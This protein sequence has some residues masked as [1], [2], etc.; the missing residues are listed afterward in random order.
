[1]RKT[2]LR[3]A[4]AAPLAL[5]LA[6]CQKEVLQVQNYNAPDV[7]RVYATPA[8]IEG[9]L[10]GGYQTV[11]SS[12]RGSSEGLGTQSHNM[13]LE[14]Y[15]SVANFGG[16]TRAAIPRIAIFNDR[17]NSVQTGN[18]RDFQ[19]LSK[20]AR[21]AATGVQAL[22][23]LVTGGGTLGSPAQNTRARAFGF[24]VNGVALGYLSFGYD[25]SAIVTVMTPSDEVPPLASY[26]DVNKAA[27]QMLDSALAVAQSAD[28]TSGINGFPLPSTW[29]TYAV[30]Q[31]AFVRLV[32]SERARIRAGVARTPA[33]RAAVDWNAVI[34]DATAGISA[35]FKLAINPTTG[36]SC[37]FDCSQMEVS[38][39]WGQ[40]SPMYYGMTDTSGFYARWIATPIGQRDGAGMFIT[41]D[42]RWPQGATRAAQTADS[43]LPL[44]P[45]KYF[46]N[47]PLGEDVA[48]DSFGTSN[49]IHSRWWF[50]RNNSGIGDY[51]HMSRT[52]MDML[53]AEGYIRTGNLAAATALI[54]TSRTRNGMPAIAVPASATV[55]ISP[56]VAGGF[57][58][59]GCVPQVP[60]PP[61]FSTVGCGSILEAMKY[62]KRM[63]T[64]FAGY[65]QWFNDSRGWGDL[66]EGTALQWPVPNVEMDARV[67]PFYNLGGLGGPSSA[68]KGTYGF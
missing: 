41:P 32:K 60:Q 11:N 12:I 30:T 22:D 53:A 35:D 3:L 66:V 65:M 1:M 5:L 21:T 33:E 29:L 4:A 54:N 61:A 48:G 64:A 8:S 31:D 62:E 55:A 36:W 13:A 25:S 18:Q 45:G 67:Q 44:P 9:V 26:A 59:Q 15:A 39:G 27:L 38:A 47:K 43:P 51:V 34:A 7:V 20:T 40:I 24:F 52:E 16:N 10:S 14:M 42:K 46:R 17:G 63:E 19:Q 23:R 28:A 2:I 50:I 56:Q 68:A 37:S 58:S 49:Y 6:G 57:T